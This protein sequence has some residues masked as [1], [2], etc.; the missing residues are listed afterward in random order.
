MNK[1]NTTSINKHPEIIVGIGAS[2]GGLQAILDFFQG[3]PV[4]TAFTYIIVQ[5]LSPDYKTMMPELLGGKTTLPVHLI[6]ENEEI[7]RGNIYMIP[8]GFNLVIENYRLRLSEKRNKLDLP[9][10]V[11]FESLADH[12]GEDAVGVVLSGTGSDGTRGIKAI[13]ESNGFAVVQDPMEAQFNGMPSS[14]VATGVVDFIL[15]VVKI[16]ECILDHYETFREDKLESVEQS[17]PDAQFKQFLK[18]IR[19]ETSVDFSLYKRS[20]LIR[21]IIRRRDLNQFATDEEY[22]TE[23][24]EAPA[25][26][27]E[28]YNDLLIGV[29]KFFRDQELWKSL[30]T[31]V[32]PAIVKN[33]RDGDTLRVWNVACST[34][35]EAYS[36]ASLLLAEIDHQQKNVD[37]KLFAT[38]LSQPHLD[39]ASLGIYETTALNEVP[40]QFR[41]G[42][43]RPVGDK[44]KITERIRKCVVFS[45]HNVLKD[46]PLN[47][48][49]LTMCRNL[50]IYFNAEAQERALQN[51]HY[52]LKLGS[53]LVLGSSEALG[54]QRRYFDTVNRKWRVFQSSQVMPRLR[55]EVLHNTMDRLDTQPNLPT[56]MRTRIPA[57]KRSAARMN[58]VSELGK[59]VLEH[60][61]AA[62]VLIDEDYNILHAEGSFS[63]FARLPKTGFSTS[64]LDMLDDELSLAV[65]SSVK[66]ARRKDSNVLH[67][68]V[69]AQSIDGEPVSID[70]LVKPIE[71]KTEHGSYTYAISLLEQK[72]ENRKSLVVETAEQLST[73]TRRIAGLQE[74]LQ[75]LRTEL[76]HA[77][78][79]AE[80]SNEELQSTNEELLAS[81][82]ELQS[83][84]EELQS[85]NEELHNVNTEHVQKMEELASLNADLDNLIASTKIAT[86]F[87]GRDMRIRRFTPDV[88]EHFNLLP[89]DVGRA[90]QDFLPRQK[91]K[92]SAGLM[93]QVKQV[94]K[95]GEPVK[96]EVKGR[97]SGYFIRSVRPFMNGN[98]EQEGVA[99]TYTDIT[100][101]KKSQLKLKR[102]EERFRS[103][104]EEDPVMHVN[105]DPKTATIVDCNK[106]VPEKLGYESKDELI[107]QPILSLYPQDWRLK[108]LDMIEGFKKSG[109]IKPTEVTMQRK[110]GTL[111][112]LSL[113]SNAYV[114]DNGEILYSRSVLTDI[115]EQ[116]NQQR[117]LE[118]Q[119]RDLEN[120]NVELEQFVSICSHDLQN[121]LGTIQFTT[122]ILRKK[123][124]ENLDNKGREYLD[125]VHDAANRMSGQIKGL[126]QYTRLGKHQEKEEVDLNEVVEGVKADLGTKIL[127][128]QAQV[129]IAPLPSINGHHSELELLFLNLMGNAL[130]YCK[131]GITPEIRVSSYPEEDGHVIVV[132]DNG[133]GIKRDFQADIFKI[134]N[135]APGSESFE[136]TG[137]G[138]AHCAKIAALHGGEIWVDSQEN[139]GSTFYVRL[140]I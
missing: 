45:R 123:Y 125:Y 128:C 99:I 107:G 87:V 91:E 12:H 70:V 85:V 104:Y 39:V 4:D 116:K 126:L 25:L 81:N 5:H 86:M 83:T 75:E 59:S 36:L 42:F 132:A 7:E 61:G 136:G 74:D 2:A 28:L 23:L 60:F 27:T 41:E 131:A 78:E 47:R 40:E 13:K 98:G 138:L 52:S 38:D 92:S 26:V 97:E 135:R 57:E 55:T 21:R 114:D 43:F 102:S 113:T 111:L 93:A 79:E 89:H 65:Q 72:I 100:E 34:G 133:I 119:A 18:L 101:I 11:F 20:T 103:F 109:L 30:A 134:F 69:I 9:I 106:L 14:A 22:L 88:K 49:D 56:G 33:K 139:V 54:P 51:I 118:Q 31:T 53:Y 124:V 66:K 35:E 10:D 108:A 37:I 8:P 48:M 19:D 127:D 71:H 112:E 121:P 90:L 64:V 50:L 58:V 32:I 82:E 77:I 122:D 1:A 140:K 24:N 129:H 76:R 29:T 46:P 62:S 15:P 117:L 68:D 137:I 73:S 130:K 96:R 115:T 94:M 105:V 16:N 3:V 44:L 63:K 17:I 120:V 67:K 110:D 84:N 80:T 6:E 95:T